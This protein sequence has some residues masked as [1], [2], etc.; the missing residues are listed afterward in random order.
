MITAGPQCDMEKKEIDAALKSANLT[1]TSLAEH[2]GVTPSAVTK[3]LNSRRPLRQDEVAQVRAFFV[4]NG[5]TG[6]ADTSIMDVRRVDTPPAIPTR[7]E[8]P[9]DVPIL[10]TA[11]GGASGD[12]TMNGETGAFARR[13]PRYQNRVDIFAL[14]VQGNSMEPRY[15]SGELIVVEKRRPPQNGDHVVVELLPDR[16]GTREAYL[17]VL[18]ARTP[19]KL[20]LRQ[21]SP[22]KE[23]EIELAKV[24]QVL[25]VLTTVDLLGI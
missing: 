25:R 24:G 2:L 1:R 10:G 11:W 12:F 21:Y 6:Y 3:M 13:P 18:V 17:K 23:I 9:M 20:K 19:T 14:Y 22:P 4:K 5:I 15:Y 7:S 16:D 8:M